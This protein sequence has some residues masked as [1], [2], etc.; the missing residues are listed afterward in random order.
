M[1]IK[2]LNSLANKAKQI[3]FKQEKNMYKKT[4]RF[5]MVEAYMLSHDVQDVLAQFKE[6]LLGL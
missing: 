3:S 1:Y 6:L 2:W 4:W 5:N